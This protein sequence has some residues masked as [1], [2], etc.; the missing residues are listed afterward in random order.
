MRLGIPTQ[1]PWMRLCWPGL[2]PLFALSCVRAGLTTVRGSA[3]RPRISG[4]GRGIV[5]MR[6]RGRAPSVGSWKKLPPAA[7]KFPMPKRG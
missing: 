7:D 2:H 5:V 6:L 1:T 4:T 3:S